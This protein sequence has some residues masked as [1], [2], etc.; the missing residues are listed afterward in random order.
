MG[1]VVVG[2]A[3]AA[4]A[5]RVVLSV[6]GTA[7]LNTWNRRLIAKVGV[8]AHGKKKYKTWFAGTQPADA[9]FK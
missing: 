3:A 6:I 4:C 5:S 9:M 1:V 7:N 2:S 8:V